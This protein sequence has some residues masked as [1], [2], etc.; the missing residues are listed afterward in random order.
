MTE[1]SVK[2]IRAYYTVD[3]VKDWHG[4]YKQK[5]KM[6]TLVKSNAWQYCKSRVSLVF[7][8]I[9]GGVVFIYGFR[10]TFNHY[11][12]H[13]LKYTAVNLLDRQT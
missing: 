10:N 3:K 12:L 4:K 6:K 13:L 5:P 9:I 7:F 1:N 2:A 8:M 11:R